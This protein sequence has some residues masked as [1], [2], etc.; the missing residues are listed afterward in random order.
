M[1][2]NI[3]NQN[4]HG[5][6]HGVWNDVWNFLCDVIKTG[7]NIKADLDFHS[8]N[9]RVLESFDLLAIVRRLGRTEE[10]YSEEI[11]IYKMILSA[12]DAIIPPSPRP[13]VPPLQQLWYQIQQPYIPTYYD[14]L[15][16]YQ[17]DLRWHTDNIPYYV[18]I[19]LGKEKGIDW[20]LDKLGSEVKGWFHKMYGTGS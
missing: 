14:F 5:V 12:R 19:K 8:D 16:D 2:D 4:N 7:I 20:L 3:Y 18:A 13:A 1:F 9:K 17:N 6:Q 11:K 10:R 15:R